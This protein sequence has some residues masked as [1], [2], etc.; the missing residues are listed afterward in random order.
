MKRTLSIVAMGVALAWATD[1]VA[2]L[3]APPITVTFSEP[4]DGTVAPSGGPAPITVAVDTGTA[5]NVSGLSTTSSAESATAT[6]SLTGVALPNTEAIMSL[7]EPGG[8]TSD[9]VSVVAATRLVN[10]GPNQT[11][12]R[13]YTISFF[14]DTEGPLPVSG[15]VPITEDGT[16]QLLYVDLDVS[17]SAR[18]DTEVPEPGTLGL[19]CSGLLGL[20]SIAAWRRS[21]HRG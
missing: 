7:T 15:V 16:L 18:S 6:F 5:T 21:S 19:L 2:V 4:A 17:V 11:F 14:S 12:I 8:G 1:A 10:P 9:Y 13:D 20:T 3:V